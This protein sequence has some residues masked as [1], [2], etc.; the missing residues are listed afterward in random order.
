[1]PFPLPMTVPSD[2]TNVSIELL[3]N[4]SFIIYGCE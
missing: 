3:I 4:K 2:C 1:M